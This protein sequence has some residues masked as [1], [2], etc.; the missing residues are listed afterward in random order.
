MLNNIKRI[1]QKHILKQQLVLNRIKKIHNLQTAKRIAMIFDVDD[2]Q[3]W[4]VINKF[5]TELSKRGKEMQLLGR[6]KQ[7]EIDFIITNTSVL[8]C[9]NDDVDFWGLPKSYAVSNFLNQHFDILI[10]TVETPDFFSQY[11]SLKVMAD[12]KIA[13]DIA[14]NENYFDLLIKLDEDNTDVKSFLKQ[15]LHYLN[16]INLKN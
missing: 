5:A 3:S 9:D 11:V 12:F 6:K 15:I 2:E 13:R 14:D 16:L 8:L 4:K 7:K 10:D 1:R